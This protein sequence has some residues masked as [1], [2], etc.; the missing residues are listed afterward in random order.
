MSSKERKRQSLRG[1]F[2]KHRLCNFSVGV[3]PM[4]K[5]LLT[6]AMAIPS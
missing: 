3:V 4:F 6:L 5:S 2:A 1:Q